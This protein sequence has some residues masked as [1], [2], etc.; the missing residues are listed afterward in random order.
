LLFSPLRPDRG[1]SESYNEGIAYVG[2]KGSNV[3]NPFI[4]PLGRN[5]MKL[6]SSDRTKALAK[7]RGIQILVSKLKGCVSENSSY[8]TA[9][10]ESTCEISEKLVAY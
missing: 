10:P 7:D 8:F 1:R 9:E 4:A 5:L 3:I 6:G 2:G